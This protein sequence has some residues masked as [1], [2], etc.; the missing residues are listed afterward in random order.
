MPEIT[1]HPFTG[2]GVDD[3]NPDLTT[4][5][6]TLD[7]ITWLSIWFGDLEVTVFGSP[8]ELVEFTAHLHEAALTARDVK[9]EEVLADFDEQDRHLAVIDNWQE[10]PDDWP[11]TGIVDG[12]VEDMGVDP[13]QYEQRE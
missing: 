4:V 13:F 7:S 3:F 11:D 10:P 2:N 12:R 8:D 6:R 1:V 9:H 5:G